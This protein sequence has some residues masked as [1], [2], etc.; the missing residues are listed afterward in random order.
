MNVKDNSLHPFPF[1]TLCKDNAIKYF[2]VLLD[3]TVFAKY[4]QLFLVT[5]SSLFLV[6]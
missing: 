1:K 2:H 6:L 4:L 3:V 5:T